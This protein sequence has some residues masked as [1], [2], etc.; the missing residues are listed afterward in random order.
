MK[1]CPCLPLCLPGLAGAQA[2]AAG[3]RGRGVGRHGAS[4][5]LCVARPAG[6]LYNLGGAS[7][8]PNPE[9][10]SKIGGRRRLFRAC[11]IHGTYT[12]PME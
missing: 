8:N 11:L 4:A 3:G 7:N 10:I 5:P 9:I 2:A 12:G 6:F 1:G